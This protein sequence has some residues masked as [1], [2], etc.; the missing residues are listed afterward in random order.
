MKFLRFSEREREILIQKGKTSVSDEE[1]LALY[2]KIYSY[3]KDQIEL[4]W[5]LGDAYPEILE[6]VAD[7]S[8]AM[9]HHNPADWEE[10]YR[11]PITLPTDRYTEARILDMVAYLLNRWRAPEAYRSLLD[12]L[13]SRQVFNYVLM[14]YV[15]AFEPEPLWE[16]FFLKELELTRI[17][18]ARSINSLEE[19]A[20]RAAEYF[21][22]YEECRR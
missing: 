1:F 21:E 6:R 17:I 4:L 15:N 8:F 3:G 19:L 12:S 5:R 18:K 14:E 7:K 16:N 22:K 9:R 20:F 11:F 13:P 2:Q 10:G